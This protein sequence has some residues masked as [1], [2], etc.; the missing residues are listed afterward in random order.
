MNNAHM[1]LRVTTAGGRTRILPALPIFFRS[2]IIFFAV[3]ALPGFTGGRAF[4]EVDGMHEHQMHNMKEPEVSVD[5]ETTPSQLK[6]GGPAEIL[7]TMKDAAGRPLRGLTVM[8]DRLMHVVIASA[9]FSVFAHIH[10]EDFGPITE[11]MRKKAEYPV[12]FTFPKAGEYIIAVDSAVEDRHFSEHFTVEVTGKPKMG[13]YR[14]DLSRERR[15]GDYQVA[16]SSVPGKIVAGKE[17]VLKY[18]IKKDGEP[19]RDLEPYLAAPMHVAII[20][21]D[22]DDFI[23]AHGEI[24][25]T[26]QGHHRMGHEEMHMSLP[27]KFGPELDVPVVFP[28]K[29]LYQIF[30]QVRHK[31]KVILLSFMIE[32]E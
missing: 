4:A 12:Q 31:G 29:G 18:T 30:S 20:S 24:P 1:F 3:L 21:S 15:F 2:C 28:G 23:H 7:F 27:E 8:H 25:G 22:L 10:P 5:I 19:V 26:A 16:L 13:S 6:A 11:E 9:D 32:V 14:E 17:A